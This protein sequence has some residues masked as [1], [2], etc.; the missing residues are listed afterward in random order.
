M[1][2]LKILEKRWKELVSKPKT[3]EEIQEILELA[4]KIDQL[5]LREYQSMIDELKK[6][7]I[8]IQSIWDLVN[9]DIKYP[10][11]IPI[12][13][14]YLPIVQD[15]KNKEGIIRSLTVPE[16][17]GIAT[18]SLLKEYNETSK[19][20]ESLRW[21]IANALK[22][23]IT[24]NDIGS[25]LPLVLDKENGLSRQMLV[26]A[27]GGKKSEQVREILEV[28]LNDEN[29][30]IRKEAKKALLKFGKNN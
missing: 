6:I 18:Q 9:S 4:K 29:Q 3:A 20:K 24:A 28:L 1:S 5:R 2:K 16:A 8:K 7:G 27:L 17:K 30:V 25:I 10:D 13:L 26:V 22:T 12:L 21:I 19:S 15:D 11:A 23:T 14:K